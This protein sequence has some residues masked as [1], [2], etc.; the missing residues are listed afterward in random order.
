MKKFIFSM[1]VLLFFSTATQ[2]K[3]EFD[4][5]DFLEAEGSSLQMG[6]VNI[7][8]NSYLKAAI[9]PDFPLGPLSVGLAFNLYL[10]LG[11]YGQPSS[12]DWVTLRYLAY[13]YQ[14]KYGFKYGQLRRITLG[15][16]MLVDNFNSGSGGNIEFTTKKAGIL[17]YVT[18]LDTKITAM[19]TAEEVQA[20]RV[21]RP[22]V[23]L[24]GVPLIVGATYAEDVDGIDDDS[25]GT[26]INR[27][28]QVGYAV[29][30]AYPIGGP[31]F[32]LYAEGASLEDHGNGYGVGAKGSVLEFIDYKAEVRHLE[33]DFVPG[34]FNSSY[35]ATGFNFATDALQEDL[36]GFLVGLGSGFMNDSFKAGMQYELYDDINVLTA[37]IGWKR[38]QRIAGVINFSKPFNSAD[39][40]G[41]AIANLHYQT[42]KFY[43]LIFTIKRI[44][45]DSNTFEESIS[46][47]TVIKPEKL[48]PNLPF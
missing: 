32:T 16:G 20:L 26:Q 8:S 24:S 22:V 10:P 15:Q 1:F 37:G 2:A 38:I 6:Y 39:D 35:Q 12:T 11:D 45:E 3:V 31:F 34:Y 13:D 47:S 18:L 42:G 5:E 14:D 40:R 30:I 48:F 23:E 41:I 33:K 7:D 25:T 29:D 44:Y 27:D 46:V 4:L 19:R 28:S 36:T 9:N 21:Q 43:D 17:G